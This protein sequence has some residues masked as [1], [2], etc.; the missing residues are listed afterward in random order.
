MAVVFYFQYLVM[1]DPE[2]KQISLEN[3]MLYITLVQKR[4]KIISIYG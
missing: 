3:H 2:L 4:P 1:E